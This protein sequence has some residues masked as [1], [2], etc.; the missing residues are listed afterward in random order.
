MRL[1]TNPHFPL[2]STMAA[3]SNPCKFGPDCRNKDTTCKFSH[4]PA[5][6][7]KFGDRCTKRD[8]AYT[9]PGSRASAPARGLCKFGDRCNNRDC[10]FLHPG[11]RAPA[12]AG[13]RR[14][15]GNGPIR[16]LTVNL[17]TEKNVN[18]AVGAAVQGDAMHLKRLLASIERKKQVLERAKKQLD[19]MEAKADAAA[20]QL[21]SILR[22][23]PAVDGDD[24]DDDAVDEVEGDE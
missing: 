24:V 14:P 17:P 2:S 21:A 9:H 15:Q 6:S 20:A 16:Q 22:S 8:C 13:A 1:R 19:A 7:C 4:A 5:G 18:F 11:A 3:V 10:G 23:A 12:R